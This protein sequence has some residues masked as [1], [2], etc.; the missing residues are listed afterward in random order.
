LD[1]IGRILSEGLRDERAVTI[2]SI[3]PQPASVNDRVTM[4]ISSPGVE[5]HVR[6]V[7]LLGR[8]LWQTS[9]LGRTLILPN[10]P[11]G[12]HLLIVRS[13]LGISSRPIIIQ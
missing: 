11:S 5:S 6:V 7:D 13:A 9:S 1:C 8:E 3:H 10:L 2:E 4:T 12:L